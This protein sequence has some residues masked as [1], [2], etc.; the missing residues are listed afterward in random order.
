M[1]DEYRKRLTHYGGSTRE[2]V[3]RDSII[4][5]ENSFTDSQS[6][7][8]V[9]MPDENG[10]FIPYDARIILDAKDSARSSGNYLI[11]FRNGVEVHSGM[12]VQIPNNYGDLEMWLIYNTSANPLFPKHIIKKCNYLLR[13]LNSKREI[14]ERWVVFDDSYKLYSGIHTYD[15]YTTTLPYFTLTATLPYD[16]ETIN[17]RCDKRFLIDKEGIEGVPDAYIVTNRNAVSKVNDDHGIINIVFSR[18]QFNHDTDNPELMIADYYTNTEDEYIENDVPNPDDGTECD[19]LF[20][21]NA[22]IKMGVPFKEFEGRA[23]NVD[24][25][26]LDI[27]DCEWQVS[28][29]PELEQYFVYEVDGA[30][31]NIKAAFNQAIAGS[32]INITFIDNTHKCSASLQ[33][34]V[35]SS[36]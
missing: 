12:Y 1:F 30:K 13:W 15:Q 31:L 32:F 2:A 23:F 22:D 5:M 29:L 6:Y 33:L 19:I 20:N 9:Y 18:Q 4:I 10:E 8:T 34:K 35:V 16:T 26:L 25:T 11:Q 7:K 3:K 17:I 28:I 14:V 21:G 36:I 27:N 24:G